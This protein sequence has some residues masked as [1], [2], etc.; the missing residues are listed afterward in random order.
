MIETNLY[1]APVTTEL[2][3]EQKP[4]SPGTSTYQHRDEQ[5]SEVHESCS[6][7]KADGHREESE[8]SKAAGLLGHVDSRG[9]EGPVGSSQH[10]LG[11]R[12]GAV[13]TT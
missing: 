3:E 9:Q 2:K 12:R 11:D 4:P 5:V 8:G 6:Q 7:S 1:L 13:R 10:D